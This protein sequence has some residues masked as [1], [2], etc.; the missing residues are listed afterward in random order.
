M[1]YVYE[2]T[3]ALLTVRSRPP[4][5]TADPEIK[6]KLPTTSIPI[7]PILAVIS[8]S[9]SVLVCSTSGTQRLLLRKL[10]T[11]PLIFMSPG[12]CMCGAILM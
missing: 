4:L 9:D 3:Y 6:R 1:M 2:C 8:D 12:N 10:L 7:Q 5:Y 11:E